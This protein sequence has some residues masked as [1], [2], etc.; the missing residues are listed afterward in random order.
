MNEKQSY[1]SIL[2]KIRKDKGLSQEAFA[3][4]LG[5][6]K[7][8]ISRY[9]TDQRTPKI[10]VAAGFAKKLNMPLNDFVTDGGLSDYP[11]S[12]NLEM[13][14]TVPADNT[15]LKTLLEE[16]ADLSEKE[17]KTVIKFIKTIKNDK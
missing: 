8:V 14:Y 15:N 1:G 12:D 3:K 10:T 9:E 2:K 11:I 6:S 4:M 7:Q 17:T 5:T 13:L 16:S